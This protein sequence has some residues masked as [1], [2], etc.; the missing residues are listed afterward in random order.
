MQNSVIHNKDNQS[1]FKSG[2]Q[3]GTG[4]RMLLDLIER[5]LVTSGHHVPIMC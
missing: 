3:C 2:R 4:S 5:A 1:E